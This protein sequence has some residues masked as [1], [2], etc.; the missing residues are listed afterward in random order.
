M[1]GLDWTGL[2]D[3]EWTV[4]SK[5]GESRFNTQLMYIVRLSSCL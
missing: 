4:V 1:T 3:M 5:G 2:M